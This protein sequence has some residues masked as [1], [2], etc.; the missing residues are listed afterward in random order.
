V[1]ETI[2][3]IENAIS[4]I[5]LLDQYPIRRQLQQLKNNPTQ[6]NSRNYNN[7]SNA[8]ESKPNNDFTINLRPILRLTCRLSLV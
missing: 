6:K 2:Q 1:K 7:V 4:E 5:M 8:Q 3:E